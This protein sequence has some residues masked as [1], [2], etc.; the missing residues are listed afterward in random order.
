[1]RGSFQRPSSRAIKPALEF[2]YGD[3]YEPTEPNETEFGL[4]V[5][6]ERVARDPKHLRSFISETG[7]GAVIDQLERLKK[8]RDEGVLTGDEFEAQK[9]RVLGN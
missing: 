9:R 2:G 7:T 4:D 5:A 6:I 1:V 3:E 8:L